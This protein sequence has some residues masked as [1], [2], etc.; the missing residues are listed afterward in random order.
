[1]TQQAQQPVQQQDVDLTF[2]LSFINAVI[3]ALDEIPH[4]WSRQ[5]I[6]SLVKSSNE[7]L[8]AMQSAEP[9]EVSLPVPKK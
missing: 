7:Q 5:V 6:D 9:S 3:Q 8:Q 1:M 2:K 4:K